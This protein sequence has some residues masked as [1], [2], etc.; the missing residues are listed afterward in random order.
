MSSST[1]PAS[2]LAVEVR[3]LSF[4]YGSHRAL[5]ELT[6]SVP[7]GELFG[8][9]G[10]NGSGKST[11]FR[12]LATILPA[13]AAAIR[14]FGNDVALQ[15]ALAR[16]LFGVT[17]QSPS[18]DGKLTVQENLTHQGHLYGLFGQE[19]KRRSAE[20]LSEFG[21]ADRRDA[22][23]DTLSGGLKRRVE[24]AK[25]LLHR[26][27]LLLLDE[28]STGLDPAIRLELWDALDRLRQSLGTTILVTTHFMDEG[29][30]CDRLALLHEGQIVAQGRPAELRS[31]LGGDCLTLESPDAIALAE[32]LTQQFSLATT[33]LG[34]TL[35]LETDA[36]STLIPQLMTT[37]PNQITSLTFAKPTLEDVFLVKTGHRLES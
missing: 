11:L 35:R 3:E 32:Q 18:L 6:L 37:F 29:E 25:C 24:L 5:K 7:E 34:N 30:R 23:V 21:L 12:L 33:R 2:L 31:S 15:P 19:L 27:K 22:K 9:L 10:P 8:L 14:L 1:A 36:A 16:R 28:P 13:P 17:F 20:L 4:A 26:P